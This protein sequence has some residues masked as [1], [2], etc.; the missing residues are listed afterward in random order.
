[1]L[2]PEVI[3]ACPS[4]GP[5]HGPQPGA[6]A[7]ARLDPLQTSSHAGEID[8]FYSEQMRGECID[9]MPFE[10]RGWRP[11]RLRIME[12]METSMQPTSRQHKFAHCGD[13]V[14]IYYEPQSK[15]VIWRGS[16]CEDRFCIPCGQ[17]RSRQIAECLRKKVEEQRTMFITLT[18]R[19]GPKDLLETQLKK[20]TDAWKQLKRS[21]VWKEHVAGG[22]IMLEVKWSVTS[23]GHWHPH[24]HL[25]CHGKWLNQD[26]LRATWFSITGDSD[27]CDVQPVVET[28]K[29]IGYVTKYASKCVD[30]SFVMRPKRLAEAI[31]AL[32]GRRLC[33][34][35]GSW[36]G[37]PLREKLE[38]EDATKVLTGWMYLGTQRDLEYRSGNGD[39][40][41]RI[42]LGEV[43]RQRAIRYALTERC[44]SN[45]ASS[46]PPPTGNVEHSNAYTDGC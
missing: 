40:E 39:K 13:D 26:R 10:H 22:A 15:E 37:T 34:C 6:A 8:R 19:G 18:V 1:M 28:A 31:H 12:A 4:S 24:Y 33:A 2:A 35:F 38:P 41:A 46:H 43:E 27:Q 29:A 21:P 25:L 20:L 7:A 16:R 45:A 44:R 14:H 5:L 23:G 36:F 17:A 42:I 32:R 9:G 3:P 30:S 11:M